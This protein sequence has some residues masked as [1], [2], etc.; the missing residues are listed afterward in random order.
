MNN[1]S[2]TLVASYCGVGNGC[3]SS[4]TPL[5]TSSASAR[6]YYRIT[7]TSETS[8]EQSTAILAQGSNLDENKAFIHLTGLFKHSGVQVPDIIEV[9]TANGSYILED[10]GD[11]VLYDLIK[12]DGWTTGNRRLMEQAI[13]ELVKLQLVSGVDRQVL[14]P[15]AAMDSRSIMWDLN[16][17]KYC[18]VKGC[19]IEFDEVQLQDEFESLASRIEEIPHQVLIHRDF[20]SRNIMVHNDR[21]YLIDYQGA[22]YAPGLYDMVSLLWQ[23]RIAC[24]DDVRRHMLEYYKARSGYC[25]SQAQTDIIIVLRMLQVLGA[26]GYRGLFQGRENFTS[27]IP[28]A[29]AT[30]CR[31]INAD[32][33]PHL[34]YV[35]KS[36]NDRFGELTARNCR[37]TPLTVTVQ[38]FSF[39][40]GYPLDPSGNG[41][42]HAFDCRALPNPGR[43]EQYKAFTGEDE[44]VIQ[45]LDAEKSMSQFLNNCCKIIDASVDNYIDRGFENLS[46]AFGCTGGRHRS[47][48]SASHAARHIK[49]KFPGVNVVVKHIAQGIEYKLP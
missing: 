43:Y 25:Y 22:R 40:Q 41:G 46:V 16:Y 37:P 42:G 10:L 7:S 1:E 23:T 35:L 5:S 29:L 9:S 24:P 44:C 19:E 48:Y 32:R 21:V 13:D 47:V 14:F 28:A 15:V 3:T 12:R 33:F 31:H 2:A 20:Q 36:L 26:Y 6:R 45:F 34:A 4:C 27:Q 18:F 38:S 11:T 30:A 17:F 8:R 49:D 39:R